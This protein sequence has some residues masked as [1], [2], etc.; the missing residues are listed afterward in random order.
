MTKVAIFTNSL[1]GGG[2]ERAMLNVASYLNDQGT[3][4]DFLVASDKG[5]LLKEVPNTV[6]LINLKSSGSGYFSLRW[7]LLKA[8]FSVESVFLLL[9][10]FLSY[11][12][13]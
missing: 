9:V 11:Q 5:P 3:S 2:M 12:N 13:R 7:W 4:V 10:F 8:A 6:N 1:S